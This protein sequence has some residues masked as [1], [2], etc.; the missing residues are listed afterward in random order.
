VRRQ[1]LTRLARG[2][3]AIDRGVQWAIRVFLAVTTRV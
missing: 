3:D 2:V 1:A